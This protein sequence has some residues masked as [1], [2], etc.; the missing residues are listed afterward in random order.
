VRFRFIER[1]SKRFGVQRLCQLLA[2]SRSG[3][4]AWRKRGSSKREREDRV[5]LALIRAAFRASHR[6]YGYRKVFAALETDIPCGRDRVARLMRENGLRGRHKRRSVVTTQ[7]HHN[8]LVA[9]NLLSQDF[10]ASTLDEKWVA[11]ITYIWTRQGWLYLAAI[12]DLFSRFIVGWAMERSLSDLLTRKALKMALGR[13]QPSGGLIHHSDRGGQYASKDYRELLRKA[14]IE[15]SMS[16][17]GNAY[18]NAP[19]E[20]FFSRLKNEW[21]HHRKYRTRDE[22]RRDIFEYIEV[23]YN[24][25]R[26]HSALGYRSPLEFEAL[27][28]TP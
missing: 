2:V 9:P 23:F 1:H 17:R 20:S 14:G 3:Y 28:V 27:H 11:D 18:D 24:R 19:I 13:R 16:R 12:E 8:L 5:L 22:A 26:V 21:I 4:Y 7:S 10:T 15:Q 6:I 25:Q